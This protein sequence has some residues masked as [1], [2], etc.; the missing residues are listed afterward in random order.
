M[1]ENS[2]TRQQNTKFHMNSKGNIWM[3]HKVQYHSISQLYI[4]TS[5]CFSGHVAII[6]TS[7]LPLKVESCFL[8]VWNICCP[9]PLL[10]LQKPLAA[11][12]TLLLETNLPEVFLSIMLPAPCHFFNREK[13]RTTPLKQSMTCRSSTCMP[14]QKVWT[15][16][17]WYSDAVDR[18]V[19]SF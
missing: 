5:P 4:S 1:K 10:L 7:D 12:D 6:C 16:V 19:L 17:F 14:V 8:A 9:I 18:E 2:D 3:K 13:S 11:G 15:C